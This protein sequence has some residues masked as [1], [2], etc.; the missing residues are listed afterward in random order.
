MTEKINNQ[1]NNQEEIQKQILESLKE[2]ID[3]ELNIDIVRLGLIKKIE[4]EDYIEEFEI[5]E[6]IKITMT[7]TSVMCPFA[8]KI[9][10]DVEEKVNELNF[11]D[12]QVELDFSE[13]WEPSEELK[14]ELGL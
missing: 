10:G 5:Y 9:I 8:D 12:V 4:L 7:L 1:K 6:N 2:I 14:M 3:P 11:G 13:P